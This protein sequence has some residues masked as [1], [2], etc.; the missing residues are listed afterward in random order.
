M[1]ALRSIY[2]WVFSVVFFSL[3]E[4]RSWQLM[5]SMNWI[6]FVCVR[7]KGG[8]ISLAMKLWCLDIVELNMWND[9]LCMC[10]KN[11]G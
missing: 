11:Y 4:I 2:E 8:A 7:K 10:C 3:D 9:I 5:N 6:V 1:V